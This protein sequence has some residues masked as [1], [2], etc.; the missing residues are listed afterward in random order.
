MTIPVDGDGWVSRQSVG[1]LHW[2]PQ[3]PVPT[4]NLLC[5]RSIG[6]STAPIPVRRGEWCDWVLPMNTL[7]EVVAEGEGILVEPTRLPAHL[8]I[9]LK[10]GS[11]GRVVFPDSHDLCIMELAEIHDHNGPH[12]AL[13]RLSFNEPRP[14]EA[15]PPRDTRHSPMFGEAPL[16][17]KYWLDVEGTL[18]RGPSAPAKN[19]HYARFGGFTDTHQRRPIWT[20][21]RSERPENVTE[22][23]EE[24]AQEYVRYREG[25]NKLGAAIAR[26]AKSHAG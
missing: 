12:Y 22:I 2:W 21:A 16:T 17:A 9:G 24:Y 20:L 25:L 4:W 8:F 5:G 23:S 6:K 26:G 18:W 3:K 11:C 7:G 14:V 13:G 19:L 10:R 15:I 1:H